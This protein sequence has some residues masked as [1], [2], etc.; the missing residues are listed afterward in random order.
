MS[1][2]SNDAAQRFGRAVDRLFVSLGPQKDET[3]WRLVS[4]CMYPRPEYGDEVAQDAA[5]AEA[6]AHRVSSLRDPAEVR[7]EVESF[8]SEFLRGRL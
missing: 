4:V 1:R 5:A 3:H 8:V 2:L 6:S 7:R